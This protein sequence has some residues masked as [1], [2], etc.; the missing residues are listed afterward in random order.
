[1]VCS[2]CPTPRPIQIPIKKWVIKHYVEV[3]TL[4]RHNSAIEYCYN[5]SVLVSVSVSVSGS[6]NAPLR[7]VIRLF[8]LKNYVVNLS[9]LRNR[10]CENI[11]LQTSQE[12]QTADVAKHDILPIWILLT[13][14][15]KKK[16]CHS[17]Q[18][19]MLLLWETI[20]Y[21]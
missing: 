21:Q 13:R 5:L 4:H 3:F 12:Y 7:S 11:Y 2:H 19:I 8:E 17:K 14:R 18:E 6:V 9:T 20:L 16:L 10:C 1:M 15:K